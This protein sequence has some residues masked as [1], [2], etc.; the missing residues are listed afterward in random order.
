MKT[1]HEIL[2]D[3]ENAK[4]TADIIDEIANDLSSRCSKPVRESCDML[5]KKWEGPAK[6]AFFKKLYGTD[7]ILDWLLGLLRRL[8]THIRNKAKRIY[9]AEMR[10][11]QIARERDSRLW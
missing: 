11:V 8:S 2:M 1:E 9:D 7:G 10:N 5:A 6:E 3:F 4:R